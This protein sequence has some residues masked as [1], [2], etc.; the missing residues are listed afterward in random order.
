MSFLKLYLIDIFFQALRKLTL[1]DP[2]DPE[3]E[4][5]PDTSNQGTG[6]NVAPPSVEV[7]FLI[8]LSNCAYMRR[9]ILPRLAESLVR[10][11]YPKAE[12]G[13]TTNFLIIFCLYNL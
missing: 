10:A 9:V 5:M 3:V 7:Q 6:N 1:K 11:G 12:V 13:F 4:D 8:T 2:D